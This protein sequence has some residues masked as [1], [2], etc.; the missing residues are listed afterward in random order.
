MKRAL[1]V[2][3]VLN[4]EIVL[5][6][7]ARA[8]VAFCEREIGAF[9]WRVRIA[10]N[11]STDRTGE[12]ARRLTAEN[13]R[14]SF[15]S[16]PERGRGRALSLSFNE[17]AA[18]ADVMAYMDI[19]L[20]SD[21]QALPALLAAAGEG[22]SVAYGSRFEPES[23]VTRQAIR[24]LTSRGYRNL[25]RLVLGVKAKDLQCGFKAVSAAAWRR[26]QGR[27]GHPGWF[28]DTELIFWAERLGMA[29]R[30]VPV[31]WVETRD[32]RRKSTVRLVPTILGYF[33]DLARL[34]LK[35]RKG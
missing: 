3:P 18:D 7:N 6:A 28:W 25:V 10:D 8:L 17:G 21:L 20:S 4:E 31:A 1:I 34:K 13:P 33:R 5:E 32:R 27:V 24:E 22:E 11:G 12:I 2:L 29:V 16:I 23:K 15:R 9:D 14:L 19:D 30:P 35:I 26:L